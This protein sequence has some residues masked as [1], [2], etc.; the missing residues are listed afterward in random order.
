[1]SYADYYL[2]QANAGRDLKRSCTLARSNMAKA[3]CQDKAQLTTLKK[4]DAQCW[5]LGVR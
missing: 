3:Y 4:V 1:M 5:K 2:R